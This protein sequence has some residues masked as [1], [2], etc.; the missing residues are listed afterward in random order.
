VGDYQRYMT[1][2][3]GDQNVP[4]LWLH[5][6]SGKKPKTIGWYTIKCVNHTLY[7]LCSIFKRKQVNLEA[8]SQVI[9]LSTIQGQCVMGFKKKENLFINNYENP[10][11]V[12]QNSK[13]VT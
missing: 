7:K 2:F 10:H 12:P 13:T 11:L 6:H 8:Y 3:L 1:L 4:E 9:I 5:L